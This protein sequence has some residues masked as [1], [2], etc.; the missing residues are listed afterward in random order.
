VSFAATA[1]D[2]TIPDE[3]GK[4]IQQHS[5]IGALDGGFFGDHV[6]LSTGNLEFVQTDV[7]LPGNDGL[8]VRVGRRLEVGRDHW[9]GHF[10]DWDRRK[11]PRQADISKAELRATRDV[12]AYRNVLVGTRTAPA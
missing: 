7:D 11:L 12:I 5:L 9:T 2:V 6:S 4:L 10:G 1:D 8:V 3:Y